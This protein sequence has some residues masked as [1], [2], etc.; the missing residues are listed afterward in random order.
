[1]PRR[2][3]E[4]ALA[5]YFY[6]AG[7]GDSLPPLPARP[8]KTATFLPQTKQ[9][10]MGNDK[11]FL[12]PEVGKRKR[13]RSRPVSKPPKEHKAHHTP[14]GESGLHRKEIVAHM[15]THLAI[16]K[17]NYKETENIYEAHPAWP[18]SLIYNKVQECIDKCKM[19]IHEART[20]T[21]TGRHK[22]N[23]EAVHS[24]RIDT[25]GWG[26]KAVHD[27]ITGYVYQSP[28]NHLTLDKPHHH[29]DGT[30][31]FVNVVLAWLFAAKRQLMSNLTMFIEQAYNKTPAMSKFLEH[32]QRGREA[33]AAY[34]SEKHKLHKRKHKSYNLE[35]QTLLDEQ[36]A[37]LYGAR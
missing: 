17:D 8:A 16:M 23:V 2:C 4:G 9:G 13:S 12:G 26:L 18:L 33:L 27:A 31:M 29:T 5:S 14:A 1:M 10:V 36:Y 35:D 3:K 11:A 7:N 15:K 32:E 25:S 19:A 20:H 30:H 34:H 6:D 22:H 21:G 24:K 28:H 37:A